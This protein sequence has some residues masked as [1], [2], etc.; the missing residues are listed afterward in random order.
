MMIPVIVPDTDMAFNFQVYAFDAYFTGDLWDTSP[1]NAADGAYHMFNAALPA[2]YADDYGPIARQAGGSV[3]SMVMGQVNNS[4][5][6]IGMYYRV[7]NGVMGGEVFG[8]ELPVDIFGDISQW[9]STSPVVPRSSSM[10]ISPP[11][12][13]G[14]LWP[15]GSS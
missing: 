5:A 14:I 15:M 9:A 12:T 1:A 2:F 11:A 13:V 8:V 3:T 10:W 6:Q 7:T 4:P